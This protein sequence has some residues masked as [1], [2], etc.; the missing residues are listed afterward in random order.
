MEL[1]QPFT[2]NHPLIYVIRNKIDTKLY[3]GR[4]K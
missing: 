1:F 4:T 2:K 3:I